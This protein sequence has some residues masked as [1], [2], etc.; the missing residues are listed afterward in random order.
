MGG[1]LFGNAALAAQ[2]RDAGLI[3]VQETL[4]ALPLAVCVALT[5]VAYVKILALALRNGS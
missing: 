4:A 1:V 2:A 5:G 3:L